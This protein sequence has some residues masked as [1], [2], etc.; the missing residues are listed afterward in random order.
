MDKFFDP[1]FPKNK[2]RKI[3]FLNHKSSSP[4]SEIK[5]IFLFLTINL[6]DYCSK[7]KLF[8]HIV[9]NL[10]KALLPAEL[11]YLIY[12]SFPESLKLMFPIKH[13]EKK[14]YSVF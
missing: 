4:A 9:M 3:K 12:V 14:S 6:S 7:Q 13:T 5:M 8:F 10:S 11:T 1:Q 2:I